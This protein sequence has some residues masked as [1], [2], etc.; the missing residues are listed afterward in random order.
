MVAQGYTQIPGVDYSESFAPVV[1]NS[2]VHVILV[3]TLYMV[4]NSDW[5]CDVIDVE[6]AFLK[7]DLSETVIIRTPEGMQSD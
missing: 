5:V 1:A 2:T 4:K 6:T 7:A 3:I